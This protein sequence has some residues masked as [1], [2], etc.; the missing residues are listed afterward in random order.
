M[1]ITDARHRENVIVDSLT[2]EGNWLALAVWQGRKGW[3][4]HPELGNGVGRHGVKGNEDSELVLSASIT[5][6]VGEDESALGGVSMLLAVSVQVSERTY[7]V[8]RSR[9]RAAI[10]E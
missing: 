7:L 1:I 2:E 9:S 8:G 3:R 4:A 5:E 6:R 10:F